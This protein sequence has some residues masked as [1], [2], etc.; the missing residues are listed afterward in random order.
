MSNRT[1]GKT[2]SQVAQE[3]M[4]LA[5]QAKVAEAA[6]S[7]KPATEYVE[8]AEIQI[9][10]QLLQ[11]ATAM[12]NARLIAMMVHENAMLEV[13]LEQERRDKFEWKAKHDALK[14]AFGA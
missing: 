1:D 10:P 3:A 8:Q 13:A 2:T 11:Q 5:A 14:A 12:R 6:E 7:E 4:A 9:D